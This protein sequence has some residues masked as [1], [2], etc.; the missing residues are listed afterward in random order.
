[1]T[2][3]EVANVVGMIAYQQRFD[4]DALATDFRSRDEISDVVYEPSENHW[5]QTWFE[6]DETYVAFYQS[7]QCS[8][9]GCQ[10][11]E[12]FH[13]TVEGVNAVM[14]DMISRE[15]EPQASIKS[16]VATTEIGMSIPLEALTVELG[17]ESV[18]YE[19]EQFPALIYRGSDYVVLV[20]SSGKLLCTGLTSLDDV[21]EAIED[22]KE[23]I[24]PVL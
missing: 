9:A 21:S 17:L 18:E 24:K 3:I 20:F 12:D 15:I 5:L 1:V 13:G 14:G 8:I 7:G 10:S 2:E 6:P 4:L 19:P 22:M 16:I 23:R 11:V